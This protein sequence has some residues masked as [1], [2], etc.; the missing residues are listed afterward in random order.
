MQTV[1]GKAPSFYGKAGIGVAVLAAA[2]ISIPTIG[3][4]ILNHINKRLPVRGI[5]RP[6]E[7]GTALHS[8]HLLPFERRTQFPD[9]PNRQCDAA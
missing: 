3:V 7:C 4:F 9:C 8:F 2:Q 1:F 5:Q 6:R